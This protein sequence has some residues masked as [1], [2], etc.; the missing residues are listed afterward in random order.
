MLIKVADDH[1]KRLALIESLQ[2]DSALDRKQREWLKDQM[3]AVRHGAK[4]ERNAAHYIDHYYKDSQNLAVIHDL[5]LELDDEVA[6]IDHMVISRGFIFY[7]FETKNFSGNLSI[8]EHGE[9][10]VHYGSGARGIPSPLEQSRR[11]EKVLS[12]WLERLEI[13]GRLGTKPQFFHAVLIGPQR[14]ITRP[15]ERKLDTSNIIKADQIE[16][17]R[18]KHIDKS[19]SVA[20]TLTA[21]MNIRGADTVREWAEKLVR[22]HR[23]LPPHQWLPDFMK[24]PSPPVPQHSAVTSIQPNAGESAVPAIASERCTCVSCGK[25]LS[26]AEQDYCAN[27]TV[28]F[29][30]Q[31]LCMTHQREF[32]ARKR[33]GAQPAAQVQAIAAAAPTVLA[34]D[35]RRRKLVCCSCGVKISFDEGKFCWSQERRFGGLQYCRTHQVDFR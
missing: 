29:E 11:H 10:T 18:N 4:G 17:W 13:T 35:P 32:R 26:T 2:N 25:A 22:Q 6:Q 33:S 3:W 23:P 30:G 1:S 28:R 21:M 27:N 19:I 8:N 14:T 7:L 5:R 16:A 34:D 12:K 15:D 9:F 20:Q 24:P 31:M